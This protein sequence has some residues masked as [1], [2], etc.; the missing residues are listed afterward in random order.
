MELIHP[1]NIAF[2]GG[3]QYGKSFAIKN[4][5]QSYPKKNV[6]AFD[7]NNEYKDFA[8]HTFYD[9]KE[10]L[11]IAKNLSNSC[12]V[13]EEA[14]SFFRNVTEDILTIMTRNFHKNNSSIFV[15]HSLRAVPVEIFDH[16]NVLFVL[17]TNDRIDLIEKKYKGILTRT[18]ISQI[19]SLPKR[20]MM[21]LKF[22]DFVK[23]N[24]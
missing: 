2:V 5:L 10:F 6:F 3:M 13:F 15:F 11:N 12:F 23:N 24:Q 19:I 8:S 17:H 16:L 22:L 20:Q 1:F 14:T 9:K 7:P 4:I 18:Q 21:T